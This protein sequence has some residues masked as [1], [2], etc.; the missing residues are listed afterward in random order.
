MTDFR[1]NRYSWRFLTFFKKNSFLRFSHKKIH[2]TPI[3][4]LTKFVRNFDFGFKT[5]LEPFRVT[6]EDH[7]SYRDHNFWTEI[8]S[9]ENRFSTTMDFSIFYCF[10]KEFLYWPLQSLLW[11]PFPSKMSQNDEKWLFQ[12]RD[13]FVGQ[14]VLTWCW[15]KYWNRFFHRKMD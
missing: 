15:P 3:W 7:F 12:N 10:Y 5:I 11:M 8:R 14:Q 9:C 2:L 13:W 6:K 1:Y 4:N